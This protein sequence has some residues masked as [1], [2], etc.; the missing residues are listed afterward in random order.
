MR[1]AKNMELSRSGWSEL[2]GLGR[3]LGKRFPAL[4]TAFGDGQ[5]DIRHTNEQTGGNRS[6]DSARAFVTGLFGEHGE[7]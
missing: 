3:R 7:D 2:E 1:P 4:R 6:R 5:H